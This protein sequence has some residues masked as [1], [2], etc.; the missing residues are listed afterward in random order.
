[1]CR[2]QVFVTMKVN[3]QK[4]LK[5]FHSLLTP[6][7]NLGKKGGTNIQ[8]VL[9]KCFLSILSGTLFFLACPTF[10]LWP[11]A[12]IG[13]I[14]L[15]MVLFDRQ[16]LPKT[17]HAFAYGFLTGFVAIS[18]GFI[19]T[20][21]FSW[22]IPFLEQFAKFPQPYS[23]PLSTT[24]FALFA[25]YHGLI[26]AFWA[27]FICFLRR[28]LRLSLTWILALSWTAFEF[29]FPCIFPWYLSL[30]Q[31]H[32]LP[33]I[34]VADLTGP[35]GVGFLLGLGNGAL[36]EIGCYLLSQRKLYLSLRTPLT[37]L[38]MIVIS[39]GYGV[40]RIH[41]IERLRAEAP[42][43]KI[44]LMQSN[45]SMSEKISQNGRDLLLS[46]YQKASEALSK[47]G[48]DLI[49]WPE[50][51]YPFIIRRYSQENRSVQFPT[52]IRTWDTTPILFGAMT[53][54]HSNEVKVY[55]SAYLIDQKGEIKGPVYKNFLLIFGE[56]V[57]FLS[58][59]PWLK[60]L[61]P[62]I[63]D[64]SAG[65]EPGTL[66]FE[67][68]GRIY[69]LGMMICYEDILPQYGRRLF[70]TQ[71]QPNILINL[72]NDAWFGKT[73][74]P[75]QHLGLSVFRAIEHRVDLVRS[76]N[77]GV[78]ALIDATGKV[79]EQSEVYDPKE[80]EVPVSTLIGMAAVVTAGGYY[81][82]LGDTFGWLCLG[83]IILCGMIAR[84]R[85][86]KP[87]HWLYLLGS[88]AFLAGIVLI[89]GSFV[90]GTDVKTTIAALAHYKEYT[91]PQA[92]LFRSIWVLSLVFPMA[93]FL[94]GITLEFI[95][96]KRKLGYTNLDPNSNARLEILISLLFVLVFPVAFWGRME[97]N[98]GL[99][100]VLTL[101]C[102]LF[103]LLGESLVFAIRKLFLKRK[104]LP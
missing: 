41:Q 68:N 8:K 100:V 95:H 19:T 49:I 57:P 104:L 85:A 44:G 87:I 80:K 24:I 90:P 20:G 26:F 79:H 22:M 2:K 28:E 27:K 60:E 59:M 77:T 32:F 3:F 14:P 36:F 15:L 97:G 81:Q 89:I 74:E 23:L 52:Q 12:W 71:Q 11:L 42:K 21:G 4:F 73:A 43:L 70:E 6:I 55:N 10:H 38:G 78:S 34:Q 72:T 7:V 16:S 91:F 9:L 5:F 51:T 63:S 29:C 53:V 17:N 40:I 33:I 75:Y 31:I 39:L 88:I 1:M 69:S 35:I 18:G 50:T 93:S 67:K 48:V 62:G 86:R 13:F 46:K 102:S 30:T 99:V 65:L 83:T 58:Y 61:V 94:M 54:D 64:I 96:Q 56:Y 84:H 98:T 66:P 101:I 76:T 45:I 25:A 82:S 103:A 92:F 37:A 47:Q